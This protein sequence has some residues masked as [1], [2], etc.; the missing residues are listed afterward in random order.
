MSI[1]PRAHSIIPLT[2]I[3][4]I[5]DWHYSCWKYTTTANCCNGSILL[6]ETLLQNS[7]KTF[8][9][10]Q[11]VFQW[12]FFAPYSRLELLPLTNDTHIHVE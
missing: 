4:A 9:I 5:H 6:T 2:W 8:L 12:V 3:Q 10:V 1:I 7:V 11:A